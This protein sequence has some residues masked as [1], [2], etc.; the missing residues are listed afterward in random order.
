MDDFKLSILYE[1]RNEYTAKLINI[2]TPLIFEGIKSIFNDAVQ[3]CEQNKEKNKY[4]LTFQRLLSNIPH[5]NMDTINNEKDRIVNKSKCDY[6]E[7]CITCVHISLLKILTAVRVGT[8]Q[9]KIDINIPNLPDFIHKVYINAARS[10]Y[11]NVYL[12]NLNNSELDKQ[13]NNNVIRQFIQEAILNTIRNNMPIEQLLRTYLDENT[14]EEIIEEIKEQDITPK[15]NLS[16]SHLSSGGD[17]ND[18]SYNSLFNNDHNNDNT[19]NKLIE[20]GDEQIDAPYMMDTSSNNPLIGETLPIVTQ[21]VIKFNDVDAVF[22]ESGQ[23]IQVNASKD[24]ERLDKI[25]EERNRQRKIAEAEEVDENGLM[26]PKNMS[27]IEEVEVDLDA[28]F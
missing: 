4:L 20:G 28:I 8:K 16:L 9:K 18:A 13:K 1:S 11:L 24:I 2:L 10:I 25:A 26:I 27:D 17:L 21:N 15:E 22:D 6:L 23:E 5:W 7:D 3:L 19:F 12:F 14:E